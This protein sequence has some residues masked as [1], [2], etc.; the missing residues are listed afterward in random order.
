MKKKLMIVVLAIMIALGGTI[1]A[2]NAVDCT[3]GCGQ[4]LEDCTC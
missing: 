2:V 1:V 4:T 3:C